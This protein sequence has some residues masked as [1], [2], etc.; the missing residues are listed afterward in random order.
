MTRGSEH[1]AG[2]PARTAVLL[3]AGRGTRLG[4]SGVDLPKGFLQV[5]GRPIVERSI[6]LLFNSGV[7]HIVIGTGHQAERYDL[8]AQRWPG[9][10][11]TV[12]NA[13]FASSGSMY[14]CG[15]AADGV[16]GDCLIVEAD[17]IYEPRALD[18]LQ[19]AGSVSMLLVSG[20]TNAG[21]EVFVEADLRGRLV[22]LSKVRD[23]LGPR[24][25]GEL[26]GITRLTAAAR[27]ALLGAARLWL[28]STRQVDYETVLTAIAREVAIRCR[29][30]DDLVWAEIDDADH[31]ARARR[32]FGD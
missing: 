10:V 12:Y 14:T 22:A 3:A 5:A 1:G 19:A 24:V 4:A 28:A 29:V 26:V 17:L 27:A 30:V 31:L 21:D 11:R 23:R 13:Q 7:E 25:V 32:L 9:R 16:E 8:L 18:V 20:F 6:D 15:L 2:S